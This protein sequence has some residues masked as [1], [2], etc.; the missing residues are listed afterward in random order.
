MIRL[1]FVE[2]LGE[3][4]SPV[5]TKSVPNFADRDLDQQGAEFHLPAKS[6]DIQEASQDRFLCNFFSLG[7]VH[8]NGPGYRKHRTQMRLH[9]TPVSLS[10]SLARLMNEC[11]LVL[12]VRLVPA[13]KIVMVVMTEIGVMPVVRSIPEA[14]CRS[15]SGP[16]RS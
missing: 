9:E 4:L 8:Q 12:Q 7:Q 15:G 1:P 2:R 5:L 13:S 14:Q 10:V 6:L 11:H 3:V 16:F